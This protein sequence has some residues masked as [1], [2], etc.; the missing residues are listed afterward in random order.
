M[1]TVV[2]VVD[3]LSAP[4]LRAIL[5]KALRRAG[6]RRVVVDLLGVTLLAAAG[7]AALTQA[8]HQALHQNVQYQPLRVVVGHDWYE[9]LRPILTRELDQALTLCHSVSEALTI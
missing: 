5:D 7:L 8:A 2:G 3:A 4:A 6:A 9:P 1:L